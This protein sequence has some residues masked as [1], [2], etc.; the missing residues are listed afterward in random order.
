MFE[1]PIACVLDC[2]WIPKV[3][4]YLVKLGFTGERAE[5]VWMTDR[6][7]SLLDRDFSRTP[8][9]H[10]TQ[11]M[12]VIGRWDDGGRYMYSR[13]QRTEFVEPE[14]YNLSDLREDL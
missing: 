7:V 11:R 6:Q 9:G 4:K 5:E 8:N 14:Q 13:F 1:R 2:R 12:T 3:R 10:S